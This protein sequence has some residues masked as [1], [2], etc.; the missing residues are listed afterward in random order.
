MSTWK[1]TTD[2]DGDVYEKWRRHL[3]ARGIQCAGKNSIIRTLNSQMLTDAI[4]SK[5]EDDK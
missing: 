4:K 3:L 2:I 1:V 5:M